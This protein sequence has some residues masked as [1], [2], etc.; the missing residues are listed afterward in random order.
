MNPIMRYLRRRRMRPL[1][2][3]LRQQYDAAVV[4]WAAGRELLSADIE[5]TKTEFGGEVP[6]GSAG[7]MLYNARRALATI[8]ADV[9]WAVGL[10]RAELAIEI[11]AD[12]GSEQHARAY[13]ADLEA[14]AQRAADVR[15]AAAR[16][17]VAVRSARRCAGK[18]A[19]ALSDLSEDTISRLILFTPTLSESLF[20]EKQRLKEQSEASAAMLNK[21]LSARR[22]LLVT[23]CELPHRKRVSARTQDKIGIALEVDEDNDA[24][25]LNGRHQEVCAAMQ[26]LHRDHFGGRGQ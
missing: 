16:D 23:A 20:E 17:L 9:G 15:A 8:D 2:A 26:A 7:G 10:R 3:Q 19:A 14:L 22:A 5:L 6:A 12:G 1:V 21:T 18:C 11:V 4:S 13:V 25:R 24:M